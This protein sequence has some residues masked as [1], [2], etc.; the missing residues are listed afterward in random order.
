MNLF[1]RI[2]T[3][4]SILILTVLGL[5]IFLV[6]G[7]TNALTST[8]LNSLDTLEVGLRILVA[9]VFLALMAFLLWLEFRRSGSRTIGV[10]SSKGGSIRIHTQDVEER[11]R[12]DVDAVSD[13]ISVKTRVTERDNA[14][15][16]KLDVIASP[17]VDLVEKG[18]AIADRVRTT[19]VEKLGLKLYGKPQVTIKTARN[20]PVQTT[21]ITPSSP[22]G[23][24]NGS[25]NPA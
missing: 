1:N 6:P 10:A 24:G 5:S 21:P 7:N 3:T 11:I 25:G 14:V 22:S 12:Q 19:V 2:F 4:I 18:E 13:V 16:A 15:V 17:G 9:L 8:L 23:P 20:K